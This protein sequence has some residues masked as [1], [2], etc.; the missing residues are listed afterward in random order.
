MNL[1]NL[2]GWPGPAGCGGGRP[3]GSSDLLGSFSAMIHLFNWDEWKKKTVFLPLLDFPFTPSAPRNINTHKLRWMT[4]LSS[5]KSKEEL[6]CQNSLVRSGLT[7]ET[8]VRLFRHINET[9]AWLMCICFLSSLFP[10]WLNLFEVVAGRSVSQHA[11]G[12]GQ[13]V[14]VIS[15]PSL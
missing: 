15:I 12:G 6:T 14:L 9:L 5:S 2:P 11:L 13:S 10:F 7:F 8:P 3:V 1:I 4:C